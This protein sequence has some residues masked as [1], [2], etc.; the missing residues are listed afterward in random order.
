MLML[1]QGTTK[2]DH[3]RSTY[4][5][6]DLNWRILSYHNSIPYNPK[7]IP[8]DPKQQWSVITDAKQ[9]PPNQIDRV[10]LGQKLVNV[11]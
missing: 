4:N 1:A 8:V 6:I 9:A 11:N 2:I 3:S 10:V 5:S 7:P